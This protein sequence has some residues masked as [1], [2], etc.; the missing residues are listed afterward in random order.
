M[1]LVRSR[2]PIDLLP[3]ACFSFVGLIAAG[4][5]RTS[6]SLSLFVHGACPHRFGA[7]GLGAIVRPARL[8]VFSPPRLLQV[9]RGCQPPLMAKS[10]SCRQGLPILSTCVPGRSGK[11][12]V[13]S[14]KANG[15]QNDSKTGEPLDVKKAS[16]RQE[17]CLLSRVPFAF[18]RPG[19]KDS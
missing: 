4:E 11:R 1:S 8:T 3:S 9:W 10:F 2:S 14:N 19:L 12:C 13:D 6:R 15:G 5:A 7:T 17:T 16:Q 18:E